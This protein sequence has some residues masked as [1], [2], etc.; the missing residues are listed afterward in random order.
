MKI[1]VEHCPIGTKFLSCKDKVLMP[2]QDLT[3]VNKAK[4]GDAQLN[5]SQQKT[6]LM[7]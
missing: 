5:V 2:R 4:V 7:M 6:L 3:D 1:D